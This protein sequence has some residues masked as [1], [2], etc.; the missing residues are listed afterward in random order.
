MTTG[1]PRSR[2]FGASSTVV[3]SLTL[4]AASDSARVAGCVGPLAAQQRE[5]SNLRLVASSISAMTVARD[6]RQI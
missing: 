3:L 4:H 2:I 6:R 5:A 1:S